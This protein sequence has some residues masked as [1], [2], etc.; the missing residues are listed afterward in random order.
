[1]RMPWSAPEEY[2]P[3]RTAPPEEGTPLQNASRASKADRQVNPQYRIRAPPPPKND[4]QA[5]TLLPQCYNPYD[6]IVSTMNPNHEAKGQRCR[7]GHFC[8]RSPRTCRLGIGITRT[9][10]PP[11]PARPES[12]CAAGRPARSGRTGCTPPRASCHGR[13]PARTPDAWRRSG[14]RKA[15]ARSSP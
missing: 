2:G 9:P 7:R 1:M 15:S 13:R 5:S 12:R 6:G 10:Q 11:W 14:R 8:P 4:R 3:I